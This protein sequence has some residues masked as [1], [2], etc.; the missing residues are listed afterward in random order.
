MEYEDSYEYEEDDRDEEEHYPQDARYLT[1][2]FQREEEPYAK[3]RM[4]IVQE[5]DTLGSIAQKYKV[6]P[7]QLSRINDLGDEDVSAGQI[8]YIPSK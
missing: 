4:C 1:S 2:M 3:M 5:S 8:L 7:T 6:P